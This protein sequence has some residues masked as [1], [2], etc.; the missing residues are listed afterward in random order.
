[1]RRGLALA[2]V[3]LLGAALRLYPIWFGIPHPQARPDETTVLGHAVAI[4]HGDPNPHFFN[5]PSLTFYLLAGVFRVATM[6]TGALT[7]VDYTLIA[8]G[9]MAIAGTATILVLHR[10]AKRV[11][12][13]ATALIASLLLAL[14][15]LHVRESHFAMTD[16][17]MTLFA[18][19]CLALLV[20]AGDTRR[21]ALFALAGLAGGL[22]TSTKY[23]AAPLVVA[24]LAVPAGWRLRLVFA[25]AFGAAF[26]AATP[27][28]LL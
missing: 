17:L 7:P 10:L 5:W 20:E 21:A 27:Y 2:G 26:V 28:A 9:C 4:L 1:M 3:V 24:V 25:V 14:P 12:G 18:T 11:A 22:A 13:D 19:A 8:R 15:I 23:S 16:A 6:V